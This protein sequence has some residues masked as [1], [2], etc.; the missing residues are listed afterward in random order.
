MFKQKTILNKQKK[1]IYQIED[2]NV[3]HLVKKILFI[4]I[5][6]VIQY[7]I[8]IKGKVIIGI[9]VNRVNIIIFNFYKIENFI[10]IENNNIKW[11]LNLFAQTIL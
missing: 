9:D 8:I 11:I 2:I 10:K 3:L 5:V 4:H 1:L 6:V 7:L